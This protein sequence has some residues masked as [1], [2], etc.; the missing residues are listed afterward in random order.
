MVPLQGRSSGD[1]GEDALE[2][3]VEKGGEDDCSVVS[4]QPEEVFGGDDVV[5][6]D[7]D[8]VFQTYYATKDTET[9]KK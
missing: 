3:V 4:E 1:S 7:G 5:D 9:Q 2:A 8:G 6:V